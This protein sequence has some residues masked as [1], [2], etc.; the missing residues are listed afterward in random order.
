[1]L[2]LPINNQYIF[3]QYI[4]ILVTSH[5]YIL[6]LVAAKPYQTPVFNAYMLANE[7]FYSALIILIFIFSDATP[8]LNIKVIAGVALVSSIFLLVLA[9]IAFNIYLMVKGK[10]RLK[11]SIKEAKLKRIEEEEKE[12][13]EEE[14]RK[15]KKKKEEEEFSSKLLLSPLNPFL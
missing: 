12:R 7:T 4:F 8:Q 13:Q 15:A 6:Y 1:L 14:E 11:E 5:I 3:L 2:C 9:N 10:D